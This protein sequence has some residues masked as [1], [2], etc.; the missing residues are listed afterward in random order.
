MEEHAQHEPLQQC[1][2]DHVCQ[3]PH[4]PQACH[5][6]NGTGGCLGAA[7]AASIELRILLP[8]PHHKPV[9]QAQVS[10]ANVTA[11]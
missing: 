1:E 2:P 10:L 6:M 5:F 9:R 3:M 7:K 8:H 11:R 4:S